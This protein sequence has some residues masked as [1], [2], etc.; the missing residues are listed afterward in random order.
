M[1]RSRQELEGRGLTGARRWYGTRTIFSMHIHFLI[2]IM[3][4]DPAATLSNCNIIPDPSST[5]ELAV[6]ADYNSNITAAGLYRFN[7]WGYDIQ[8]LCGYFRSEDFVAGAGWSG[9]IGSFS[10]RGEASWFQSVKN[11]SD[12]TGTGIFTAGIDKVFKNNS[13]AQIQIMYCNDPFRMNSFNSFYTGNMSTRNLAFSRFSSFGQFSY[14]VT[15]LFNLSVSAMWFPDLKGFFAGPS[16]D[17]SVAENVDFSVFWQHFESKISMVT[18]RIN[19]GFLRIK[20]SF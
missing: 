10:F 17:Y 18:S 11:F 3:L 5:F 19:L 7:K 6:K 9:S 4:N 15:P 16:F 1:G 20:F 8:I 14:P 12:S 13:T 2:L